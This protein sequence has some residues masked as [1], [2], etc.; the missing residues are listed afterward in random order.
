LTVGGSTA[1]AR[2]ACAQSRERRRVGSPN[3]WGTH[4]EHRLY[5]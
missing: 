2:R 1:A 5:N 3:I 4:T